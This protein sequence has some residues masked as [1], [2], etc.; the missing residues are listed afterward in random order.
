EASRRLGLGPAPDL[1]RKRGLARE[2]LGEH[3][4]A[5]ADLETALEAARATGARA[6]EW[7]SLV[8]LGLLWAE[9]DYARSG[10]LFERAL[11]LARDIGD[12]A[13]IS[14][15]LDRRGNWLV[16]IGRTGEGS[17]AHEESLRLSRE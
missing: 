15:S 8:D 7:S 13:L 6:A 1:Y 11:A 9:R 5:R 12:P 10:E 17:A 14:R 3:E 16:N 2:T 4:M